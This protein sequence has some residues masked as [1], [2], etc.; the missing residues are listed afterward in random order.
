MIEAEDELR[1]GNPEVAEDD[2]N[3]L[4]EDEDQVNNPITFVQP[5][6]T[7]PPG[8]GDF[9]TESL[10]AFPPVD[11]GDE[12]LQGDLVE[13]ARARESGLWLLG[14]RQATSRR[15]AQEFNDRSGLGLYPDK[16]GDAIS[17]PV[18]AQEVDNNDAISNACPAGLP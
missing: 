15:F 11:F 5:D 4:L 10:G 3:A 18:P 1:N 14:D 7:S 16:P 12:P 6:L 9:A 17:L 8:G 2:V 13:L